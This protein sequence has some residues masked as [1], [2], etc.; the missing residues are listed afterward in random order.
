MDSPSLFNTLIVSVGTVPPGPYAANRRSSRSA[1][2]NVRT[3]VGSG[4]GSVRSC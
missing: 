2:A 1:R 4:A 3:V